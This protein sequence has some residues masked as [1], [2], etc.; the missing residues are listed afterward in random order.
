MT[1][2]MAWLVLIRS[3]LSGGF[4]S[5]P[6]GHRTKE[7]LGYQSV[8][9]ME[10]PVVT[11]RSR[12]LGYRFLFAEP[13]W[14]L[15]GSRWV[16]DIERY[17]PV[18]K[19]SNDGY[20]LDGAY[21]PPLMDQMRY[22]IDSL[23]Q[24]RDSRQAV[25]TFWR[26]SPRHSADIPCTIALQFLLRESQIHCIASMRSSDAWL[27]WPYDVFTFTMI[28]T[29]VLLRLKERNPMTESF[30]LGKL[31]LTAGSQHLYDS[32]IERASDALVNSVMQDY[33]GLKIDKLKSSR[34]FMARLLHERDNVN[35]IGEKLAR[36]MA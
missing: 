33:I 15:S 32:V 5:S 12:D 2:D 27:G 6:R 7:L 9:N 13:H 29:Y 18:K 19:F 16:D 8:I 10:Y 28:T 30:S 26:P 24:M 34:D 22:I 4:T 3:I 23:D 20:T 31:Y 14:I 17:A 1:A 35:P 25:A 21:G 36:L 11:V